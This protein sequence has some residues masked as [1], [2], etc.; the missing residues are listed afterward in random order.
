MIMMKKIMIIKRVMYVLISIIMISIT[1]S[2]KSK[3]KCPDFTQVDGKV[4]VDRHGLVKKK[5]FSA[6]RSTPNF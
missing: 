6:P 1:P 4:K 3:K 2:C 5:R